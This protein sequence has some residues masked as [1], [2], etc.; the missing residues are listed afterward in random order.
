MARQAERQART[1][2]LQAKAAELGQVRQQL[3]AVRSELVARQ[4]E[5]RELETKQGEG[6]VANQQE[7][8]Q[9]G[10]PLGRTAQEIVHENRLEFPRHATPLVS[11]I[12]PVFNKWNYTYECLKN[13]LHNT[14]HVPYEVIVAD[15]A[16]TDQTH[17]TLASVK[18]VRAVRNETN[19][20][21]LQNAN[22]GAQHAKGEYLLFLNNDVYV[23]PGW[24]AWMVALGR[25]DERV[26]LVG[27]KLV[28]PDG[29]LQEAGGII[30][31]DA[32]GWNYGR[33]D[34]PDLPEYNYVKEVDYCSGACLLVRKTVWQA[35]GGF[36]ARFTPAYYEDV[37]LAFQARALGYKVVYQPQAVVVHVE[38]VSHGRDAQAGLKRYQIDN[39]DKFREKWAASLAQEHCR[40]GEQ[41]FSARERSFQTDIIVVVDHLVPAW[42][43]DAGSR[44][45]YQYIKLLQGLGYKIVLA[46]DNFDKAEPYT[47][48]FQ[49]MGIE[50]L[51]GPWYNREVFVEWIKKNG[52]YIKYV[53]LNR[54]DITFRYI[55]FFKAHSRA[56]I[57]YHA[58]DLHWLRTQ[59]RYELEKDE[60]LLAEIQRWQTIEDSVIAKSDTT[61]LVSHFEVEFLKKRFPDKD[62]QYV[63]IF[64]YDTVPLSQGKEF[65]KRTGILFVGSGHPPNL[66]GL[67]WFL[68]EVFPSLEKRIP[69]IIFSVCGSN[70]TVEETDT[71]R[72][73]GYISDTKL[74][75]M[76]NTTRIVVAPLR[77]G[78][79]MKGKIIEA[80]A[81]GVPV[82]TTSIGA[83]GLL[84]IDHILPACDEPHR[85]AETVEM[86]YT[87]S[88]LWT[89]RSENGLQYIRENFSVERGKE[90]YQNSLKRGPEDV[91]AEQERNS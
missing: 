30:W 24:L 55:D 40:N 51:Y 38:G 74:A 50:V 12:I 53:I 21:F 68:A 59:R 13:I 15:D 2:I 36:D 82:V 52:S 87:D 42:D 65:E 39:K 43:K 75:E 35:V 49:Q 76:Y 8:E 83:E 86:L 88:A 61:F 31:E 23:Q 17:T 41:V 14:E 46:G 57:I 27:A 5:L 58:I 29:T 37:D 44:A 56:K 11:I 47:S 18:N 81:F 4:K 90:I 28:Y 63:P 1:T 9:E 32:S 34:D 66:D 25:R 20:G 89:A 67:R 16:S 77:Y 33:S 60:S 73:L 45:I 80:M 79:G 64:L 84:D 3:V 54:P 78:G 71:V 70:I 7:K 62:L 10:V 69:D 72:V 19:L 26:A 85:F 91:E 6:P 48:G 22:N